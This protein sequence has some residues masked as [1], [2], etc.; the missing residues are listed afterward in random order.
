M[1]IDPWVRGDSTKA[2]RSKMRLTLLF[3]EEQSTFLPTRG[4]ESCPL[5]SMSV[6]VSNGK[7]HV[8]RRSFFP[9]KNDV[10]SN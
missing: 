9:G 6:G 3:L 4:K 5:P 10:G 1:A 8:G 2:A 7:A